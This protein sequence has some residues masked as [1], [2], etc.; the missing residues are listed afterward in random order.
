MATLG[1]WVVDK[2]LLPRKAVADGVTWRRNLL[3][4]QAFLGW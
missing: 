1:W 4:L 2:P 3:V